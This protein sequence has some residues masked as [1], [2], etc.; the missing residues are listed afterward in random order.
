MWR[1][2]SLTIKIGPIDGLIFFMTLLLFLMKV[3]EYTAIL[4][5]VTLVVM[6]QLGR[7]GLNLVVFFRLIRRKLHGNYRPII[8]SKRTFRRRARW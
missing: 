1:N 2:S 8:I 6:W 5:G 4:A 3:N 7:R